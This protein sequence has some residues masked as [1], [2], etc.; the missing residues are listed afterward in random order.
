MIAHDP[1]LFPG[2]RQNPAYRFI[3]IALYDGVVVLYI[4]DD[5]AIA[6]LENGLI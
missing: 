1:G 6:I 4:Q 3:A 5:N 2:L